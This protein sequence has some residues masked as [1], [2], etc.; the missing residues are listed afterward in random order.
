VT[1]VR[2]A[3]ADELDLV[4][5][6]LGAAFADY[7]WTRWTVDG[8]DHVRRV[9]A[10][11][12][13]ALERVGL[14]YGEVWVANVDEAVAAVAV[15]MDSAVAIPAPVWTAMAAE[16]VALEGDRHDAS[17]V[18]EQLTQGMRPAGRH[19]YLATV[20]TAPAAQRRGL[21]SA[22]LTPVLRRA[23]AEQVPAYLETSATSNLDF[24]AG[25]GF[26]VTDHRQLPDGGPPVWAMTRLPR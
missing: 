25:H 26:T 14:P 9:T 8:R 11:Q 2:R 13:L 7:P 17:V 4:A 21:G 20:G 12:R 24:Y 16:Q 23:D 22:V 19:Y 6:V 15:W 5:A 3:T 1:T 18:A 10:L